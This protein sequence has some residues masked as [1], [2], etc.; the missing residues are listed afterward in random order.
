MLG[1]LT[2]F[3]RQTGGDRVL[4]PVRE[5]DGEASGPFHRRGD[6]GILPTQHQ[7]A[8]LNAPGRCAPRPPRGDPDSRQRP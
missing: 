6:L 1:R 7:I 5:L 4:L 3:A 2:H 8:V